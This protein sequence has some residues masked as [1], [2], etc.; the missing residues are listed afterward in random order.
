M[1]IKEDG[2]D[3]E[4][5]LGDDDLDLIQRTIK[6]QNKTSFGLNLHKAGEGEDEPANVNEISVNFN[7]AAA[8]AADQPPAKIGAAKDK[9]QEQIDEFKSMQMAKQQAK[10]KDKGKT[11]SRDYYK[12]EI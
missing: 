8:M 12:I 1:A 11:K 7:N 3:E 2:E 4:D 5:S 9:E 10:K 6:E